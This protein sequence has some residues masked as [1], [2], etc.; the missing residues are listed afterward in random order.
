MNTVADRAVLELAE[1][2]NGKES[3]LIT[4]ST[5]VV[6]RAKRVAPGIFSDLVA[7]FPMPRP[8]VV[9]IPDKAREEENPDD[10][11]YLSRLREAQAQLAKAMSDA[12]ILLGTLM[13]SIPDDFPRE[14]DTQWLEE[15]RVL[16]YDLRSTAARYL[17]WVK[18]KAAETTEDFNAIWEGVGRLSGTSERDVKQAVKSFRR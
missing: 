14:D 16:G 17:A 4:L 12:V 1:R 3:N 7:R 10:P 13:E 18:F 15:M 2:S 8:P 6:L 5:G 11:D 9:Y